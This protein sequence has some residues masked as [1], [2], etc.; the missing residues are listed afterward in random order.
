M[1]IK[2]ALA[3]IIAGGVLILAWEQLSPRTTRMSNVSAFRPLK[4]NQVNSPEQALAA[5]ITVTRDD[6]KL[7][8][9]DPITL[10]TY[11]N[12]VSFAVFGLQVGTWE[13]DK[14]G[15]A[16]SAKGNEIYLNMGAIR[17]LSSPS[18]VELVAHEYGHNMQQLL[19][20]NRVSP[21]PRWI[22]EGFASWIAAQVLGSL[23][24][25]DYEI[26][27]HR[28]L[29][30]LAHNPEALST[31]SWLDKTE[32][33]NQ[34]LLKPKGAVRT[35]TLAFVA[36][37]RLIEAEGIPALMNYFKSGMFDS[38]FGVSSD[39]F[40]RDYDRFVTNLSKQKDL[41]FK[42]VKPNW[43]VG[44]SWTYA[45]TVHGATTVEKREVVG[46][47]RFQN[48]AYFDVKVGNENV[49]YTKDTLGQLLSIE[50]GKITS[51]RNRPSVILHWPLEPKKVWRNSYRVEDLKRQIKVD[52]DHI[53][54]VSNI[55]KITVP[56][57]VF[58]T[59]KVEAYDSKTGRMMA[60]Y[61]YSPKTKSIVKFRSYVFVDGFR[62]D[63]LIDFKL[64]D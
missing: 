52:I 38:S 33:W 51:R 26:S 43:N 25:Q 41:D 34:Q 16:G 49:L 15:I 8:V 64:A 2:F 17:G 18:F 22:Q 55:E 28:A 42:I 23:K 1:R 24:W 3:S 29:R 60:E 63:Q 27:L 21:L 40:V 46:E 56:A 50:E 35:Y 6:L 31:L 58:D 47:T 19:S 12:S 45:R 13:V 5:V 7:P 20:I 39:Q 37:H 61:W 32:N 53:M 57:G 11:K 4:P 30:E 54:V 62:E 10:Y 59:A 44:D 9:V 48:E 14:I 36:V